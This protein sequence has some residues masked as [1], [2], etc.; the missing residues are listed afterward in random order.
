MTTPKNLV[1]E[2]TTQ[3]ASPFTLTTVAR[4]FNNAFGTG[5]TDLFT[6]FMY[7]RSVPSEWMVFTGHLSSSNVM[8]VDTVI[9]GSNGTTAVAWS[10]GTKDVTND[11]PAQATREVL[12]ANRTYYVRTD[13]NDS[14]NGLS[15][16]AGGAFLTIQKAYNVIA[17]TLDLAG[18]TVTIQIADGTYTGAT[19]FSQPWTGGGAVTIQGNNTTPANVIID[20]SGGAGDCFKSTTVL[21]GILTVKDLKM[22]STTALS[23][24]TVA[25]AGTIQFGNVNF[26]ATGQF[27]V[28]AS[29]PGALAQSVS[30]YTISGG[31]TAHWR[32]SN[33][34]QIIDQVRTITISGTPAFSTAFAWASR[35]GGLLVN[36]NTFSG[37]ATGVRYT[38]DWNG[39][40]F[41]NGAGATY[42]PGNAAGTTASGGQYA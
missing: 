24:I 20:T 34:G 9:E 4:S 22:V 30:D 39:E 3:T 41:V 2:T 10:A 33:G 6:A 19:L 7:N 14:N 12:L 36:A 5:G 28:Q 13:G 17:G 1:W 25:A 11:I 37:T 23:L 42:L 27:H 16:T 26:G 31:C 15:N 32:A 8:V 38:A 40:I 29:G 21:P 35:V 18:F